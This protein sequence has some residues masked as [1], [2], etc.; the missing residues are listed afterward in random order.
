MATLEYDTSSAVGNYNQNLLFPLTI[1]IEYVS[2]DGY[3]GATL[4]IKVRGHR[5]DYDKDGFSNVQFENSDNL[6]Y[7]DKN[8]TYI[9]PKEDQYITEFYVDVSCSGS[10]K[11]TFSSGTYFC[12]YGTTG[13]GERG[14]KVTLT[15]ASELNPWYYVDYYDGD[16]EY[17]KSDSYYSGKETTILSTGPSK[18]DAPADSST[19]TITGNANGGYF[20]SKTVITDVLT[21]TK[22]GTY[23]YSFTSWN[24]EKDGKGTTYIPG[25]STTMPK[26]SLKLYAIYTSSTSYE[27]TNNTISSLKEPSRDGT[28]PS[29][30]QYTVTFNVKGGTVSSDSQ[31][32]KTTRKWS[33]GGWATTDSATSA[34]AE[35]S[36]TDT[37]NLYAYW[38]YQDVKGTATLPTPTRIGY[39][40]LGWGTSET[41][42]TNLLPAGS[43]P[44]IGANTTYYAIWKADGS[45]RIY[46]DDTKKYQIAMVW[47]YYPTSPTDLRPWK[48]VIP[49]MKTSS[50]W[51]IT[52]G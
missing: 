39:K 10:G 26:S 35:D 9:Q 27:Y 38:K 22:E 23:K 50:D 42:T 13:S 4:Y 18:S 8:T 30:L 43:T 3:G 14:I 21:A 44:E 16:G 33:F 15:K 40:F 20:S 17:Y 49:Y 24:T 5:G 34:D 28:Q 45:I 51:K 37:T 2:H 12:I 6:L 25:E 19:F 48:L 47:I 41:Q 7:F 36:Y 1:S 31:T 29:E 46:T 52:A 11:A 32:V